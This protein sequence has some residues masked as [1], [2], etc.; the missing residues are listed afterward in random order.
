MI[1]VAYLAVRWALKQFEK[2]VASGG[3]E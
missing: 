1:L 3:E 2:R